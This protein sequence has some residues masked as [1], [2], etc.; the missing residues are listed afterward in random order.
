MRCFTKSSKSTLF[1]APGP[2]RRFR[3][4]LLQAQ[5]QQCK[6][7]RASLNQVIWRERLLLIQVFPP[8]STPTGGR[9]DYL[10]GLL[11][12]NDNY[13]EFTGE[14]IGTKS[15]SFAHILKG[16]LRLLLLSSPAPYNTHCLWPSRLHLQSLTT[17]KLSFAPRFTVF[18]FLKAQYIKSQSHIIGRVILL[19]LT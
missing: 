8:T 15:K 1:L 18:N 9:L 6:K 10:Q 13:F 16:S 12:R 4:G 14:I 2:Q 19:N 7:G 17:E 5:V 3:S 11:F